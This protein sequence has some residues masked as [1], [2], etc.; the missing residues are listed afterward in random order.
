MAEAVSLLVRYAGGDVFSV[1]PFS[2][3]SLR[4]VFSNLW[5]DVSFWLR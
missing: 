5:G 4:L 3:L 1:L 2:S